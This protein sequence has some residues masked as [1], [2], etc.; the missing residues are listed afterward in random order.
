MRLGLLMMRN[1][2]HAR[3][4]HLSLDAQWLIEGRLSRSDLIT[5]T[6]PIRN[7]LSN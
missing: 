4:M 5:L 3:Y 7:F 6:P 2:A 1:V